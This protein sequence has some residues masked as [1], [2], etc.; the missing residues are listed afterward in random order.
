MPT[1]PSARVFC[2]R[3]VI[4]LLLMIVGLI[5]GHAA[6]ALLGAL[7]P[8]DRFRVRQFLTPLLHM[9]VLA[10]SVA[11]AVLLGRLV[12]R[13]AR[14]L[15]P[16][17]TGSIA[18]VGMLSGAWVDMASSP[19]NE[20]I[21]FALRL[22]GLFAGVL[23]ATVWRQ[24]PR[25]NDAPDLPDDGTCPSCASTVVRRPNGCF[26][27]LIAGTFY[28]GLY[29]LHEHLGEEWRLQSPIA[30]VALAAAFVV[31]GISAFATVASFLWG[32][33]KCQSCGHRWR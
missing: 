10:A 7:M 5:V 17:L 20:N 33:H 14:R 31:A 26:P 3:A 32:R 28:F 30:G 22:S 16:L 27:P 24:R 21:S 13:T 29:G 25:A 1:T 2:R 11:G 23:G 19:G 18:A 8:G 12:S 15:N 6:I 4:I 9:P